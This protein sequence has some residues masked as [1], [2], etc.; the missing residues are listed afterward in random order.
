MGKEEQPSD[1]VI[2]RMHLVGEAEL[3]EAK[4]PGK[5]SESLQALINLCLVDPP[6]SLLIFP[7]SVSLVH[8]ADMSNLHDGIW[9]L[10]SNDLI[11]DRM[12]FF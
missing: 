11:K 6:S 10:T 8:A 5:L 7:A 2:T 4:T 1:A 3:Y 9:P 12:Q